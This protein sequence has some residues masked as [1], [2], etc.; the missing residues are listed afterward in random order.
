MTL[1]ADA[2]SDLLIEL[3][4]DGGLDA[5]A[6]RWQGPLC[7]GAV[8][9]QVCAI[10][11]EETLAAGA[12]LREALCL[13]H[14]FETATRTD[15]AFGVERVGDL[16]GCGG[17]RTGLM[18]S[19]EGA[20]WLADDAWLLDV[21]VR[22]GVRMLAPTYNELNGLGGGCLT[23]D[24]LSRAGRDLVARLPSVGVLLDLAHASRRTFFD[25]LDLVPTAIVSH[26]ACRAL[27]DHP[28]NL[29]DAQ[30][31]ALRDCGGVLGIM[32]HPLVLDPDPAQATVSRVAE[33]CEHV[34]EVAGVAHVALGG[35]FLRQIARALG[36]ADEVVVPGI[37]MDAAV[38]GLAGPDDYGALLACLRQ[39][40]W[41]EADLAALAG[42]NLRRVLTRTLPR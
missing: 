9:L 7:R 37:T 2:H 17:G 29:D 27:Y 8:T 13:A 20:G 16:A 34:A 39:R 40:G 24:G 35:D 18:L 4:H 5:F 19:V 31:R 32:P 33:H 14:A 11:V 6:R 12:G 10:F 22:L 26:A 21:L 23:A 1:V 15:G 28:R 36:W 38:D 30:L 42:G 25:A 3:A 41:G